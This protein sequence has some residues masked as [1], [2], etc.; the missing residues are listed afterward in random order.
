LVDTT[1]L[2]NQP[3]FP[4]RIHPTPAE[5]EAAFDKMAGHIRIWTP[6]EI[7]FADRIYDLCGVE[8][9]REYLTVRKT[10]QGDEEMKEAI[11][12]IKNQLAGIQAKRK[13]NDEVIKAAA[14]AQEDNKNL[15]LAET[16]LKRSIE[17]LE[18][19]APSLAA[20]KGFSI[21]KDAAPKTRAPRTTITPAG[22][23]FG[24]AYNYL[25]EH[26][27]ADTQTIATAIGMDMTKVSAALSYD[28]TKG[29]HRVAR[30]GET[31][32]WHVITPANGH[33]PQHAGSFA[34]AS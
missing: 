18:K 3:V 24:P 16:E 21:H 15:D 20:T 27:P 2:V 17:S 4:P 1:P 34:A 7:V 13:Q 10:S 28:S 9:F 29:K 8:K 11:Q 6:E 23:N 19:L 26:G 33:A 30:D 14:D 32:R 22:G 12:Q 25:V 31:G 5:R